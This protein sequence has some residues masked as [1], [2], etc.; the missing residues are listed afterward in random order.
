VDNVADSWTSSKNKRVALTVFGVFGPVICASRFY[1]LQMKVKKS[2]LH[3]FRAVLLMSLCVTVLY[4]L[5]NTRTQSAVLCSQ[6]KVIYT[7]NE[8]DLQRTFSVTVDSRSLR[9]SQLLQDILWSYQHYHADRR[10]ELG[11]GRTSRTLTWYCDSDCGGIGDRVKGMYRAFLLALVT[12]RTFFIHMSDQV[13]STMFLEPNSIDWRPVHKCI[14]LHR[15][16]TL[17]P[18]SVLNKVFGA[19]GNL[20]LELNRL[21][22]VDDM[23]ISGKGCIPCTLKSI[24]QSA[25]SA[26]LSPSHLGLLEAVLESGT[27]GASLHSFTSKLYDFL[28]RLPQQVTQMTDSKLAQLKL[29]PRGFVAV[30]IRT[31]FKNSLLG[32]ISLLNTQFWKSTRFARSQD[33]WR[34][35]LNCALN[36]SDSKFGTNSTVLVVS[37]DR[38]PKNWA[39]FVY[40][41]RVTMLDID[42]VH[43][44]NKLTLGFLKARSRDEYLDTWVELSVMAQS[45]G[46]VSIHSGYSEVASHMGPIDPLS[47]YTY[48]IS[49]KTCSHLTL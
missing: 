47:V 17:Q 14:E 5:R 25:V 38:E 40:K 15:E 23:Y 37:D 31:G 6:Q 49:L 19:R 46:I 28:F 16:Q 4:C 34:N 44:A 20:S 13:Q 32:E 48:D 39:A 22:A 26:T 33:S 11:G 30:H 42:P 36:I 1:Y 29:K 45:W 3:L 7:R 8:E 24:L 43:V 12:N 35:I 27:G 18:F 2:T 10:R 9:Y 41:S 21:E